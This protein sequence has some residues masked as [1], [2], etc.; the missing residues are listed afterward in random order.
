MKLSGKVGIVTGAT[1]GIG[2]A[3]ARL[4]ASEGA[5]MVLAGRSPRDGEAAAESIRKEGG[6]AIFVATDVAS[7]RDVKALVAH[8]LAEF[9][10][11]DILVNNAG[12]EIGKPLLETTE[13]EWDHLLG[14]N[15]KGH[16]L[17]ATAAVPAMRARGGGSIVNTS[18]VLA[19]GTMAG[20]GAYSASK[21]A[22]IGL[23]RSMALEWSPLGIRV[24]CILPGSTDTDMM[25]FGIAEDEL[26]DRRHAEEDVLPLGRV[27]RPDEIAQATLW[28]CSDAASFA[29]GSLLLVDGGAMSEYPGPRWQPKAARASVS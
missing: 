18:S 23:T 20:C 4:L 9:G 1:R 6:R 12:T 22:I 2:L 7:S 19:L 24:N 28:F 26:E 29:S 21:A 5:A 13:E 14:V 3:T 17:C 16:F 11:I 8:T 15:L 27:G 25:W 10:G